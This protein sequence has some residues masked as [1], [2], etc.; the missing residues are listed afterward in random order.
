MT[1]T[2]AVLRWQPRRLSRREAYALALELK[3]KDRKLKMG[4]QNPKCAGVCRERSIR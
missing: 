4:A 3:R 1:A 2:A